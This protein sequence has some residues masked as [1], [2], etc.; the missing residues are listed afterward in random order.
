MV[1]STSNAITIQQVTDPLKVGTQALNWNG[2]VQTQARLLLQILTILK[3][4]SCRGA[5][6]FHDKTFN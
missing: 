3:N 1:I 6:A 5:I 2:F 4:V